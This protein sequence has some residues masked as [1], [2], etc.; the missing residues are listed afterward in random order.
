MPI[1]IATLQNSL[2]IAYYICSLSICLD[3]EGK[4]VS[5]AKNCHH[6]TIANLYYP[7]I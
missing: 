4:L 1:Y 3:I 5:L 2:D 7:Q 6:L